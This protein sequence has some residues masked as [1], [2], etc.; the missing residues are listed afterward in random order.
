MFSPRLSNLTA[1]SKRPPTP[2]RL[3]GALSAMRPAPRPKSGAS[4]LPGPEEATKKFS[5][6]ASARHSR[7]SAQYAGGYCALHTSQ[8]MRFAS[9]TAS[10]V[11]REPARYFDIR[12]SA[13]PLAPI[14]PTKQAGNQS[15]RGVHPS[16]DSA[17]LCATASVTAG[18]KPSGLRPAVPGF[19]FAPGANER[20]ENATRTNGTT[21]RSRPFKA[22]DKA[23]NEE[24]CTDEINH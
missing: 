6:S 13:N 12:F 17:S 24:E 19:L 23:L 14:S 9:L 21:F 16:F 7:H 20:E 1:P 4:V 18:R 8:S 3:N 10:Y 5:D 11:P 22:I 2:G 15:A